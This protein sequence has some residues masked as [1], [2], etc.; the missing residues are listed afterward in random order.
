VAIILVR[1][2]ETNE[3]HAQIVQHADVGLSQRGH[4]QAKLLATRLQ[5]FNIQHIFCSDLMRTQQTSSHYLD[6]NDVPISY[7]PW[8]RERN[9]GDLRGTPY[10]EV[11]YDF[12]EIDSSPKNGENIAVFAFRIEQAWKQIQMRAKFCSADLLV[13]SHGLVCRTLVANHLTLCNNS[14]LPRKWENTSITVFENES[15]FE[16]KMLNDSSHLDGDVRS[17]ISSGAV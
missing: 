6:I 2:G 3:N 1:H 5:S 10:A 8:L 17:S 15:P 4:Q 7:T 16:V 13:V 9:F 12:T 11:G 14:E